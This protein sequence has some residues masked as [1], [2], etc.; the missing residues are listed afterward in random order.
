MPLESRVKKGVKLLQVVADKKRLDHLLSFWLPLRATVKQVPVKMTQKLSI[1]FGQQVFDRETLEKQLASKP[2]VTEE[3]EKEESY[4]DDEEDDD[5]VVDT[6]QMQFLTEG[7]DV[8]L[9]SFQRGIGNISAIPEIKGMKLEESMHE[10]EL[11]KDFHFL[12]G[13]KAEPDDS[14][15]LK[16]E[17]LSMQSPRPIFDLKGSRHYEEDVKVMT[18]IEHLTQNLVQV[19][20]ELEQLKKF[21][22]ISNQAQQPMIAA[23][24][25]EQQ[26]P[27]EKDMIE[28]YEMKAADSCDVEEAQPKVGAAVRNHQNRKQSEA[29][30]T[31]SIARNIKLAE[32]KQKR[33]LN[34]S[35][36]HDF[37]G[38]EVGG[39]Y[40]GEDAMSN[41]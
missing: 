22:L 13:L 20:Q 16:D 17:F 39:E 19:T 27:T 36:E 33:N 8:G 2:L 7:D 30:D 25:G 9:A 3:E 38:F 21:L 6:S 37:E 24:S 28:Y 14:L 35:R 34:D 5:V 11:F 29:S 40:N 26:F 12:G 32:Q 31:D 10:D 4:Y 18:N 23:S 15:F 41:E 1:D